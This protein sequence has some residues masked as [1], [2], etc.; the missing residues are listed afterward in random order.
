MAGLI[1]FTNPTV[2]AAHARF[3]Q[4]KQSGM[5]DDQ[6]IAQMD[7]E[8]TLVP[9]GQLAAKVMAL[10][11]AAQQ[12][13]MP[14]Q[15]TINEQVDQQLQ[16]LQNPQLPQQQG[17]GALPEAQQAQ[18]AQQGQPQ[19]PQGMPPEM[20]QGVGAL[21]APNVGNPAAYAAGGIVAF[22]DGGD[23]KH[24]DGLS[25]SVVTDPDRAEYEKLKRIIEPTT[26]T[27]DQGEIVPVYNPDT[28]RLAHDPRVKMRYDELKQKLAQKDALAKQTQNALAEQQ[29]SAGITQQATAQGIN[30]PPPQTTPTTTTP[31]TAPESTP[32]ADFDISKYA[33]AA[34]NAKDTNPFAA[35][36]AA[37]SKTAAYPDIKKVLEGVESRDSIK[38]RKEAEL[39]AYKKAHGIGN[40]ENELI[41]YLKSQSDEFDKNKEFNKNMLLAKAG[42]TLASTPGSFLQGLA[43]A[44]VGTAQ[45]MMELNAKDK[46]LRKQNQLAML[47]AKAAKEKGDMAEFHDLQ[48]D[49]DST[50]K[51]LMSNAVQMAQLT[52]TITHYANADKVAAQNAANTSKYYNALTS[53]S[54]QQYRLMQQIA[55]MRKDPA[56]KA[57]S[58]EQQ[59]AK[60]QEL[61]Q[62]W[63]DIQMGLP[64][65]L[66]KQAT[67][68]ANQSAAIT[69]ALQNDIGV[70]QASRAYTAALATKDQS[71]INAALA[72]LNT[73]KKIA[74]ASI[75]PDEAGGANLG[76]LD[77]LTSEVE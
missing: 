20:Q 23:V 51:E 27:M 48:Q 72:A 26:Y 68:S 17:I 59:Q 39:E 40:A 29:R 21:P 53:S 60:I 14:P 18:A 74:I 46:E 41:D 13:P 32:V 57:L 43:K 30:L 52:A 49:I 54:A 15:N 65:V 36:T 58:P 50:H 7:Q 42:F 5:P 56:F 16:Q 73:A 38:A 31:S 44:G 37:S 19:A 62:P 24:Y 71:K 75:S 69:K 63:S 12:T 6:I 76:G 8:K 22:N 67:L 66:N 4:L 10:K 33:Q 77:A 61:M 28:E 2:D 3:M 11:N 55:D 70:Q 9:L 25:G 64:S 35:S 1:N 45:D 47:Q 34:Y